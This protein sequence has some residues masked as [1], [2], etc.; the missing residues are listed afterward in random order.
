Q[1]AV[2]AEI[3]MYD[4][5]TGNFLWSG[6]HTARIH[7]GGLSV[8]PLGIIA[9]VI[10]TAMNVRDIQLLRACDDLFRDMVKTI[11][12]PAI[13]EALRPPVISL[14]TQDTKNLPKKAGD[15]IN[16]V[17]QGTP[18]MQAYFDIGEFKKHIDMREMEP[19]WY[20][21]SYKVLPGDNT[22]QAMIVGFLADDAGSASQW[23]DA[24]GTVTIDTTPPEKIKNLQTVGRNKLLIL[25]WDKSQ[26]ADLAGYRLY[27]SS[28]P[29]S[30]FQEVARNEINEW[31]D[32]KV[33]NGHNYY[34]FVTAVDWAGNESEK[35]DPVLGLPIA[36][37]PT[38]VNGPIE[39]DTT[40]Y[41][42]AS[43]YIID[44]TILVKD[45]ATLTIEPG[46]E[47]RSAGG[48]LIIEGQIKAIGTK[49][50][51]I[52]FNSTQEG[53]AWEGILFNNTREKEHQLAFLRISKAKAAISCEA[54]SPRL[55]DSELTV[56]LTALKIVGA[57]SRPQLQRNAIH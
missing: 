12:V 41:S 10:A 8:T 1:V 18:G 55:E 16:V 37:G 17:I 23:V 50:H 56:N 34:Y 30:G 7:E 49:E 40:W 53:R 33:T 21:G 13:A 11:P 9:T 39:V 6:Q 45:K 57:F 14:L 51:L 26:A 22:S 48:G 4:T 24:I 44:Q 20:L 5:K 29:L 36:P 3:K 43:P 46:T 15:E 35:I 28:T 19:G 2:G 47:I 38:A 31:R 32:E 52:T 42:G 27:R 54:S 25:N